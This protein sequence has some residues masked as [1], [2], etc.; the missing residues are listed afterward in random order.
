MRFGVQGTIKPVLAITLGIF[1]LIAGGLLF[2]FGTLS[3][4]EML[5]KDLK[6]E[7]LRSALEKST[8]SLAE[9]AGLGLG[10]MLANPMIDGLIDALTPMQCVRGL[11]RL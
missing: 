8:G 3:P 9:K 4:C 7:V 5:K 11:V 2:R 6:G 1:T 10:L